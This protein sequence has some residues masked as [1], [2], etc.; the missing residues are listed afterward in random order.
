MKQW[1]LV[2]SRVFQL[3]PF[4]LTTGISHNYANLFRCHI[5][6][7]TLL[8]VVCGRRVMKGSPESLWS[9]SVQ[10]VSTF[11]LTVRS[12]LICIFVVGAGTMTACRM[13]CRYKIVSSQ[14]TTTRRGSHLS[15]AAKWWRV[16]RGTAI[17][18]T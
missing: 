11:N 15:G 10:E 9:C 2:G 4:V 14:V 17:C 6:S 16:Q 8:L 3:I 18:V 12:I 7:T 1:M 5:R 13:G